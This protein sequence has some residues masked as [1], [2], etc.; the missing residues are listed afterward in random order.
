M[1]HNSYTYVYNINRKCHILATH[2]KEVDN[3]NST[4]ETFQPF[5]LAINQDEFSKLIDKYGP[6]A[7]AKKMGISRTQLWRVLKGHCGPGEDFITAFKRAFPNQ[8]FD[9]FFLIK[10][11]Q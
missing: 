10:V 8:E 2:L 5:K 4:T 1:L 9:K 11:L 3:L 7:L 6:I